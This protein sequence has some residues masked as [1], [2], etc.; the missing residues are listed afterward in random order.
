VC[1]CASLCV[2][3]GGDGTCAEYLFACLTTVT[4]HTVITIRRAARIAI[5]TN[6]AF[7]THVFFAFLAKVMIHAGIVE[8]TCDDS[9]YKSVNK[10]VTRV[11][12]E[13]SK[14]VTRVLPLHSSQRN[15]SP[16]SQV[17][18]KASLHA[19]QCRSTKSISS[20]RV[21]VAQA[22]AWQIIQEVVY[23]GTSVKSPQ[24]MHVHGHSQFSH[25]ASKHSGHWR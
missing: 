9:C 16:S 18:Q 6:T 4:E 11:V 21:H 22:V 13:C 8:V 14:G 20:L 25:T 5:K 3:R 2:W 19:S 7:L 23:F 12:Q 24:H 10:G 15:D 1:V 17:L